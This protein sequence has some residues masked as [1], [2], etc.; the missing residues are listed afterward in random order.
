MKLS[1]I[2]YS[3]MIILAGLLVMTTG[4]D[5]DGDAGPDLT[6]ETKVYTLE[7]V[8]ESGVL[9]TATFEELEGG[10]TLVTLEL[11]G[12]PNDG[13]H[14]AHIHMNSA[15]EGGGIAI[16]L[17]NVD[18]S[19][20]TSTTTISETDA[21][22][23]IT[24]S[25]LLT[26]DG[27]INVHLSPNDLATVVAQGDIGANELTGESKMYALNQ[28]AVDG[29]SGSINFQERQDGTTLATIELNGTPSGGSHPAH[30]HENTYAETGGIL[31]SFNNV[32]GDTGVSQTQVEESDAG[33]AISYS[34][35]LELDAYVNVHLSS[36]DLATIVAQNDIGVNEF[37][38]ESITYNLEEQNSS[39][40][41]GTI[42]F[43]ERMD[44]T[45]LATF[46]LNGTP[47]DGNHPAHIHMN[48]A[49]ETGPIV[50]TFTNVNG[51]TG[52]SLT[53]VEELNDGTSFT[54]S[55]ALNYDG[56]VNV[57]LS[58]DDLT[59]VAQTNIGANST[60][61]SSS[62]GGGGSDY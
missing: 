8:N 10:E 47:D 32:D 61:S 22:D 6:G 5:D 29:I 53:Q 36:S 49:S 4:C 17:E 1:R 48:S 50:V 19:T 45:F 9:G 33:N 24:Y 51:A 20:G 42:T 15:V 23:A 18:G 14:P 21:G 7:E 3:T 38:G 62:N 52:R 27:Y 12:T 34:D 39:G 35:I 41:T 46:D 25:Q 44:D 55:E 16:S 26:Y 40:V 37:T 31:V 28:R 30:I 54:Y 57:H 60:Q 56:Y 13:N 59:V 58:P 11:T 2:F 43:D